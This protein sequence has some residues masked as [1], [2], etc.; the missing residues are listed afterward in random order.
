[1]TRPYRRLL[2]ATDFSP[3]S[4]AALAQV[5]RL[6]ARG[7]A[8]EID[9]VHVLEPLPFVVPP[10]PVIGF[11]RAREEGAQRQL[12]RSAAALRRRLGTRARVQ[13]HLENG[14]AATE[15]CRLAT[16]LGVD[17]ILIGTHGRTGLEHV[18]AGSVAERVVR[19][20][21]RPVLTVPLRRRRAGAA[22][23]R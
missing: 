22:T 18:L 21:Q 10:A 12:E 23:M 4:R 7:T 1:V 9:L 8:L 2:V 6:A 11:E 16:E 14:P 19:H 5:D 15:I 3:G 20:A 17:L 13:V